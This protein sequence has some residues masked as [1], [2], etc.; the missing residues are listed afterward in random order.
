[1]WTV[2]HFWAVTFHSLASK[3][4]LLEAKELQVKGRRCLVLDPNRAEVRL[5]LHWLPTEVPDDLVR[6]ALEPLGKVEGVER[7]TWREQGFS[8]VETTTRRVRLKL[9]DGVTTERLP[10]QL[11]IL[12]ANTLVIVPGRAPMCSRCRRNGH[13]RRDCRAP[14]CDSCRRFGHLKEDC[15]QT[16]AT[17]TSVEPKD[18]NSELLIDEVEAEAIVGE[19]KSTD[20]A[21][22]QRP[23]LSTAESSDMYTPLTM[24]STEAASAGVTKESKTI[25]FHLMQAAEDTKSSL[26]KRGDNGQIEETTMDVI[27]GTTGKRPLDLAESEYTEGEDDSDAPLQRP[28]WQPVK[29]RKSRTIKARGPTDDRC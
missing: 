24:P 18:P 8:G 10:H 11:R 12:N 7:E 21:P 6:K 27:E 5:K 3:H 28:P 4:K 14:R 23:S 22:T 25:D 26:T 16:Y 13:V 19:T 1:M 29:A 2:P 17:V 20:A 9:K 15:V